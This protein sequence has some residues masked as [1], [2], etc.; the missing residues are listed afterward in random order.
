MPEGHGV[1]TLVPQAVRSDTPQPT[2]G[3]YCAALPIAAYGHAAA[4]MR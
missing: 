1:G 2:Y 3:Q 4:L